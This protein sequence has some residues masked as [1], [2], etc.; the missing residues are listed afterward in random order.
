[1]LL[2]WTPV[3]CVQPVLLCPSRTQLLDTFVTWLSIHNQTEKC[4]MYGF[5]VQ[6][7]DGDVSDVMNDLIGN[8]GTS[9]PPKPKGETMDGQ[10]YENLT[11]M[12]L[13]WGWFRLRNPP[14]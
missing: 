1:M 8:Y 10:T 14:L 4:T 9:F 7:L 2:D 5:S 3:G 12:V 13:R 6:H 11:L